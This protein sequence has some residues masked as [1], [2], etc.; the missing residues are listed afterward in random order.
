MKGSSAANY[1]GLVLSGVAYARV[2]ALGSIYVGPA[3]VVLPRDR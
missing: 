1:C 2:Y 3:G